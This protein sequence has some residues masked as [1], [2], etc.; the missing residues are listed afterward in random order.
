MHSNKSEPDLKTEEVP[1][2]KLR[3]NLLLAVL[4]DKHRLVLD[5]TINLS[6]LQSKSLNKVNNLWDCLVLLK[7]N[8]VLEPKICPYK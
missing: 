1:I 6:H 7:M 8:L 5:K 2:R 3:D 4:K